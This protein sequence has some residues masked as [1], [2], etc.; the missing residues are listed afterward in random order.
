ME[1]ILVIL[2]FLIKS[3]YFYD[4]FYEFLKIYKIIAIIFQFI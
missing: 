4:W 3:K 1:Q 2:S